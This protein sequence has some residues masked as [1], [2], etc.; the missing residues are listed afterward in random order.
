M[1]CGEALY[2]AWSRLHAAARRAIGL[3]EDQCNL[4]P[5]VEQAGE[6]PRGEFRS[7]GEC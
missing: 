1:L 2:R 4:V 6:R 3:R 5:G 7:T